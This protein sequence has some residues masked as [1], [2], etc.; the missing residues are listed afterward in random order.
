MRYVAVP[1]VPLK[2]QLNPAFKFPDVTPNNPPI[3]ATP[4]LRAV[5]AKVFEA[6]LGVVPHRTVTDIVEP[7]VPVAV[8]VKIAVHR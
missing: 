3:E 6:T 1:I 4:P 2:V 5:F 7:P 8:H